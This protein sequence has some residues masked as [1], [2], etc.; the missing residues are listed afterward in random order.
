[1]LRAGR[2][3]QDEKRITVTT[4]QSMINVYRDYSAGY[5]DLIIT[6][7][8]HR[9]IYGKWSGILKYFDGIQI[10]LTATPFTSA[11]EHT[12]DEEDKQFVRDTLRFFGMCCGGQFSHSNI[13]VLECEN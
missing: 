10:G 11:V 4:L 12:G 3:F 9:S 2:R 8:C 13:F 5:F 7:G 1:M 6:D